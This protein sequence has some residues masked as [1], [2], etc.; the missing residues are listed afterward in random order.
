MDLWYIK[1]TLYKSFLNWKKTSK[2]VTGKTPLF[3]ISPFCT[4][5]S[6]C[7]LLAPDMVFWYGNDAF[8]ILVLSTKKQSS[9]LKKV[10]VFQKIGFKVKILK[11]F[12]ISTDCHIK[13]CWSLKWGSILKIP[14]LCSFCWLQRRTL[15]SDTFFGKWKHFKNDEKCFL[16]HFKSSFCSQDI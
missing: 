3:V 15:R 6:L 13:I 16:F 10:F 5:Y 12:K 14:I 1:L 7:L 2:V 9:F 8:S 4:H 11:K